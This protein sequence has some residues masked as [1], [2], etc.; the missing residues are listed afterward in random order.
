MGDI[1]A[2]SIKILTDLDPS[3]LKKSLSSLDKIIST[4]FKAYSAALAAVSTAIIKVGKD[5]N[6]AFATFEQ[7][8]G[9]VEK[10]FGDSADALMAYA[11]EAYATAG[12]SANAYMDT[13]TS[14][15]ASLI[16]SLGGDT[17]KAVEY[18]NAALKD[19]SDNANTFGTDMASV[20]DAYQGFAKQNFTML[21][22][23]KLGYGGT[24]EEMQ[25]LLSDAEKI[26][27][28]K[29]DISS[30][31]DITQAIHVM[32]EEM[33]IAGTTAKEAAKTIEGSANMTKAAWQNVLMAL[34]NSD[35]D[36]GEYISK[37]AESF[38]TYLGNLL[39]AVDTFISR[40]DQELFSGISHALTKIIGQLSSYIP[41]VFELGANVL[42]A[43]IQGFVGAIPDLVPAVIQ[44]A[45]AIITGFMEAIPLVVSGISSFLM[46][47]FES[48][49]PVLPQAFSVLYNAVNDVLL[50]LGEQLANGDQLIEII[51]T[52]IN[53]IINLFTIYTPLFLETAVTFLSSLINAIPVVINALV[54][55]LPQ[56]I[57]TLTTFLAKSIP[58]FL[59]ASVQLL[60]QIVNAIPTII[61]T[62]V[63]A[64]PDIINCII[65]FW[66]ENYPTII[67]SVTNALENALPTI[68]EASI[69]MFLGIIM[70]IPQIVNLLFKATPQIISALV[71]GLMQ[72]LSAML[73][74]GV[75]LVKGIWSGISSSLGWIKDRI[76]SWVGNVTSFVKRLFKINSPSKLWEDQIGKNLA[77]GIG[78][79][80][81][82]EIGGVQ[83][84]MAQ[85]LKGLTNMESKIDIG[86]NKKIALD[87]MANVRLSEMNDSKPIVVQSVLD[88]NVISETVANYNQKFSL[89]Y[90]V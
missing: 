8:K 78:V 11:N 40:F 85:S 75:N 71:A 51:V 53:S 32:Q 7:M 16:T 59:D 39:P 34:S 86:Y 20:Q 79:G 48:L 3:G 2:G 43:I 52:V 5:S 45:M 61:D 37:F 15:S 77:L 22:N 31:S 65:T 33:G 47:V 42:N 82:D 54:A 28:I 83:K 21:D 25:R 26:S 13:V 70:A 35:A 81:D 72:G 84:D 1:V 36:L 9:G 10:L 87:A 88:G 27:G 90:G 23:L 63:T 30:F 19:M 89:R 73:N 58:A 50:S 4:G 41:A 24:K 66:T 38:S 69:Q 14:F 17:K 56:I 76:T 68:I 55:A 64:L 80:F 6:A 29:Y 44:S 60:L 62:L 18:A 49:I 67:T 12:M 74:V 57:N 46:A